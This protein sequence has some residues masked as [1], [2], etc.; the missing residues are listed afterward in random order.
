LIEKVLEALK[1]V[2]GVVEPIVL[3]VEDRNKILELERQAEKRT[4]MGIWPGVNI[5]VR[6]ALNRQVVV[7]ALTTEEFQWPIKTVEL[8]CNGEVIGEQVSFEEAERLKEKGNIVIGNF[9]I[10]KEKFIKADKAKVKLLIL[11]LKLEELKVE[12]VKDL[13]VGSPSVPADL[14]IKSI[15][16][17]S[18]ASKYRNCGSIIV[19]FNL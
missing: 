19:G 8:V 1:K 6:E 11:P 14:Y 3:S 4:L 12:G 15:I 7:A 13:V 18:K 9:V 17:L 16:G 10:Y 2:K 5:G